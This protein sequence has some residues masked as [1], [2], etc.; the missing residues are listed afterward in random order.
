MQ[1]VERGLGFRHSGR[2]LEVFPGPLT[3]GLRIQIEGLIVNDAL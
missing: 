3:E 1:E 2:V